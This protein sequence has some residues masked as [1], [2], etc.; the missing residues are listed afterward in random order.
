VNKRT[1]N[2]RAAYTQLYRNEEIVFQV[3]QVLVELCE[4]F[5]ARFELDPFDKPDFMLF[6]Q[7]C[8]LFKEGLKP[9]FI[10]KHFHGELFHHHL[11]NLLLTELRQNV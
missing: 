6:E 5:E 9:E 7:R 11:R 10:F 8:Y 3:N 4:I 2:Y 1:G